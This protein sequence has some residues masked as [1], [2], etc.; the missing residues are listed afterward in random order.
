MGDRITLQQRGLDDNGDRLGPWEVVPSEAGDGSWAA[1]IIRLK[2]GEQVME[3]RLQGVQ[4]AVIV[5]RA[6]TV[7]L[8]ICSA[9]RAIDM[10]S[11]QVH[12][13]TAAN[14]TEDRAWVEVLTTAKAGETVVL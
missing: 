14:K 5:L 6:S 2:G 1:K 7:T 11:G 9:W 4:P 13:I 3:Q 12:E 10:L 8:A